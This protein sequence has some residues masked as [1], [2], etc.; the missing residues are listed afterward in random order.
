MLNLARHLLAG[1]GSFS[2]AALL[3]FAA[4][5]A[6]AAFAAT[7]TYEYDTLGR[8][9]KVT[10]DNGI[11]TTYTLDAAGNRLQVDELLP[12]TA[13]GSITVPGSSLTGIYNVSWT[14]A[15]TTV[16][17]YEL[18]ESTS[19]SFASQTRVYSGTGLSLGLT[20]K[21]NGTYYYRVRGCNG[22]ACTAYRTGG[23]GIV[24]TLPPG[25]PANIGVPT[26]STTGSYSIGWGAA[27]G[28]FTAYQL[29]ESTSSTFTTVTQ[30]YSGTL[31]TFAIT[32]KGS[33]TYFYRIRAC[34]GP[35]CSAWVNGSNSILVTRPP[36][37]PASITIPA[38]DPDGNY[39]VSWGSASGV[40]TAYEL[41]E[42]S[43]SS[44]TGAVRVYNSTGT[45]FSVTGKG[46]GTFYYRVRACNVSQCSGYRTG[47]NSI[48][49][50]VPPSA[51][52][53]ITVPTS[54]S[55]GTFTIS[56]GAATGTTT[57]YE[58]Y[59]ATNSS[60]TGAT[61]VYNS[62]GTSTSLTGRAN[63]TYYYRVRACNGASCSGYATGANP[64]VV[65]LAPGVP[66]SIAVP[67]TNNSGSYSISW[68]TATGTLTAYELYEANNSSFTGQ[69]RIYNSTGTSHAISG[70]GNGTFYYRVRAC[71]G[72]S[73]SGYRTGANSIVVT[74]PPGAPASI[75]VPATNNTGSVTISWGAAIGTLTAYELYEANN[76]SF[77][78]A[79][80]VYN[81]TGTSTTLTRGNGTYYYRV[82]ACNSGQCSGYATGANS[83]VVTIPPAAPAAI[84]VPATTGGTSYSITWVA[85]PSGT[86]TAYEV[87]ESTSSSF[88]TQTNVFSGTA[89]SAPITGRATG[90]YYYRVRACNS[91]QC[92][93]YT[94][95]SN[96]IVVDRSNPTQP[97]TPSFSIV[98]TTVTAT[99][100]GSTD[101]VAVAGY[102]YSLNGASW[103]NIGTGTSYSIQGLA[104]NTAYTFGIRARD[105]VGNV[106]LGSSAPFTTGPPPPDM[107]TGLTYN[108]IADCAY[109][110]NWNSAA[111]ATYYIFA[112]TNLNQQQLT[113]LEAQVS[114]TQ[115][116]PESNKPKWVQACNATTCSTKANF[117]AAN[118]FTPPTTPGT[119]QFSNLSS[120]SV[121]V[122][123]SPSSDF[124]GIAGY[125]YNYG[126]GWV[127]IGSVAN[128]SLS[129]LSPSSSY[130]FSV[131][132][133]DNAGLTGS[134]SSAPF[135]TPA[136][137]DTTPPSTPP[138]VGVSGVMSTSATVSWGNASDNVGVTG[139][140]YRVNGAGW[141]DRGLNLSVFLNLSA[142]T[143][144][145][146]EVQARDGAGNRSTVPGSVSFQTPLGAPA[147]P[148]G[149]SYWQEAS[150]SWRAQW[151]ASPGATYYWFRESAGTERS[152]TGTS[153]SVSC[154]WDD[155]N[156]NKPRWVQAC[157]TNGCSSKVDF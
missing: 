7:T 92:S 93:G 99:W 150:C 119:P 124:S 74:L 149:L 43:N 71:N 118:D 116:N 132:A 134:A 102:A 55:N 140:E 79:T 33:G 49:V 3:L 82:R 130:T 136:A 51:P 66:A 107:P 50:T 126:P 42:A 127:S 147:A 104:A 88:S 91:G 44:F 38:S 90:T 16:A 141:I 100:S 128:V 39:T 28:T 70:K 73:C 95:G 48:V 69:T 64:L 20:G 8:L 29:E 156:A 63:G 12:A 5:S 86:V 98:G 153:T 129:G 72:A 21:G 18:W 76:S 125:D 24:V 62:T 37:V 108:Q 27:T 83:L 142:N 26:T 4:L 17:A 135:S 154:P 32:G 6:A 25:P 59:E 34:N 87:Y 58:L 53:S 11:Q 113:G 52:P 1:T 30:L 45:S 155:P 112:D 109:R 105:A 40:L 138:S 152:V 110:A 10:Q 114:C 19:S 133:R 80:A 61:R 94:T 137:P 101:N 89:T 60:F 36:G 35:A 15:G 13:P 81:S 106:S 56:W 9:R 145:T 41:Y 144:Y 103:I 47:S 123:W 78:G 65:A 117:G 97:G 46:N 143:A 22:S 120:T 121:T 148:T 157:N 151:N 67:A 54:S 115:G 77:T 85:S 111:H 75:S 68:G 57:A 96:G 139:Y 122:T 2:R 23:N 84:T 146:I 31:R 14:A 131:R